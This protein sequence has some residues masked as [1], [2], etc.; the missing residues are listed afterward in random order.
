MGKT[1]YMI[2][3]I[4]KP[5]SEERKWAD[6]VKDRVVAPV[7]T[8]LGYSPPQ[9]SDK[10]QAESMIMPGI[11][12]QMFEADL[13]IADL[14]DLN[15]NAFYELGIR[16]CARKPVIHLIKDGQEPPFDLAGNR[17]IFISRDYDMVIKAHAEIQGRIQAI[18]KNPDQ[19]YSHVETYM[20]RKQLD[21]LK[22]TGDQEKSQIAEALQQLLRM[23][24]SN[25]DML[26]EVH[27]ITVGQPKTLKRVSLADLDVVT[28][29]DGTTVEVR[30]K[31]VSL[32]TTQ[33]PDFDP[34]TGEGRG[35]R[36]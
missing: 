4:G 33:P 2:G 14:T 27:K 36:E 12:D 24:E 30:H 20:M 34:D 11:V 31:P 19:F 10:D 32:T 5:D 1:C 8:E 17:A 18:Q 25:S 23:V 13:V 3:P 15:P 16:N 35:W 28:L 7:V 26:G 29:S 6:F 21:V 22:T 9:R